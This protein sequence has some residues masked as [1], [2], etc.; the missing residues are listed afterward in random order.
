MATVV[1]GVTHDR[2]EGCREMA[3]LTCLQYLL[4][5]RLFV[6]P[7]RPYRPLWPSPH[8]TILPNG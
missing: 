4:D 3:S 2:K 1:V 8:T 5:V 6:S 7:K